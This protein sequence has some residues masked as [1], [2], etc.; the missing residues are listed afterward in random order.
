MAR[1]PGSREVVVGCGD[2]KVRI[3]DLT[4]RGVRHVLRHDEVEGVIGV[5]Y[6][7]YGRLI[8]GGGEMVKVWAER[9]G[10]AGGGSESDSDSEEDS[11]KDTSDSEEEK[12]QKKK[13]KGKGAAKGEGGTPNGV[14]G[15]QGMD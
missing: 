8:S 7:C 11:D 5:G 10:G 14:I 13:R 12:P 6:D 15:F 4:G 1:V 3:V 9:E 2:G